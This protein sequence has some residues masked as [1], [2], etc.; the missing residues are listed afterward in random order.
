[1]LVRRDIPKDDLLIIGKSTSKLVP[2][3]HELLS[4]SSVGLVA[5]NDSSTARLLA[6][7]VVPARP[8]QL[9]VKY[10]RQLKP[11]SYNYADPESHTPPAHP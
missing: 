2:E 11:T 5:A 7:V 9:L 8:R 1:M 6:G 3:M 10:T 4:G